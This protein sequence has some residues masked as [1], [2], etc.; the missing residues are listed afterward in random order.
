MDRI[1]YITIAGKTY[2]LNFSVV[3]ADEVT[4]RYGS[5]AGI[6]YAIGLKTDEPTEENQT[7]DEK[8]VTKTYSEMIWLLALL[9]RQGVEYKKIMGE[10]ALT[11][12]DAD[13]L[14]V[15]LSRVDLRL[16]LPT[17]LNAIT[18]GLSATVETEEK[19]VETAQ[20]N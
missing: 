9:M 19:N 11:P 1:T 13:A 18:L 17:V 2:P 10:E 5:I 6:N 20:S 12:L 14:A 15:L 8:E 3:A 16:L 7:L 4:A